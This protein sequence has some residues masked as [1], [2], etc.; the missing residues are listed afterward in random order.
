MQK[1]SGR[2]SAGGGRGQGKKG[3]K[4]AKG[5]KGAAGGCISFVPFL[6]P[7][8]Y[9]LQPAVYSRRPIV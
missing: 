8:A 3:V 5:E 4:S 9:S 1:K 7:K 6:Q 2:L